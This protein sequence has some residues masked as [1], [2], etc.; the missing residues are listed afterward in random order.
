MSGTY[1]GDRAIQQ[2]TFGEEGSDAIHLASD[3]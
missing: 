3:P 1:T 2:W